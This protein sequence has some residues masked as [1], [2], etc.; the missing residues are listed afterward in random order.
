[1]AAA[2]TLVFSLVLLVLVIERTTAKKGPQVSDVV[3]W[4]KYTF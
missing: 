1:M 2:I 3:S 4:I